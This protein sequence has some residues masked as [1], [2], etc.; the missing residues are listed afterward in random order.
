MV[1]PRPGARPHPSVAYGPRP[2]GPSIHTFRGRCS[3]DVVGD[4][5]ISRKLQQPATA[6]RAVAAAPKRVCRRCTSSAR[7]HPPDRRTG[8]TGRE[9]E[10]AADDGNPVLSP[11]VSTPPVVPVDE[12]TPILHRPCTRQTYGRPTM[13]VWLLALALARAVP[14]QPW[15]FSACDLQLLCCASTCIYEMPPRLPPPSAGDLPLL[16]SSES[17]IA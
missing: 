3:W 10:E 13:D 5:S 8:Q 17:S 9:G 2:T 15:G 11:F 16:S 1:V 7:P 6:R 12:G 14:A 4:P